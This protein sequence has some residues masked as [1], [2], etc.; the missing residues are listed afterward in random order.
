MRISAKTRYGLA[1]VIRM[2]ECADPSECVTIISMAQRLHISK[3]YLEQVFALLKR[4][5]VVH[6]IQGAQGGYLLSRPAEEI[7]VYQVLAAL[8]SSMF[9]KAADTVTESD[10]SIEDTMHSRVFSVMDGV[11]KNTLS[12]ITIRA[13]A[14]EAASV[15]EDSGY[16][17]YL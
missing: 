1:A 8:E 11:L 17:Y 5:G 13:L 7:T 12:G 9:E 10:R 3:I 14:E 15:R 2:A 4:G 16:M 6:S